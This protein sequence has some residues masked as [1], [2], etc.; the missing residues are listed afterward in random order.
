MGMGLTMNLSK[1]VA[2][3]VVLACGAALAAQRR[4]P[5]NTIGARLVL[6]GGQDYGDPPFYISRQKVTIGQW[7]KVMGGDFG[8]NEDMDSPARDVS[9]RMV[10]NFCKRLSQIEGREY[11]PA[12][13]AE[14]RHAGLAE[15]QAGPAWQGGGGFSLV[16]PSAAHDADSAGPDRAKA[17]YDEAPRLVA[18]P[19]QPP[20]IPPSSD[21]GQTVSVEAVVGADGIP[22]SAKA[23]AGAKLLQPAAVEYVL[24]WRFEPAT[25]DGQPV[26][27]KSVMVVPFPKKVGE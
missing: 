14:L 26:M 23:L 24:Q 16:C 11:R 1:T 7:A 12:T 8:L 9:R 25:I 19:P 27:A 17:L 18:F 20:R 3:C 2:V 5:V 13:L 10:Q 6:V 22:L 4:S 21:D 15:Y